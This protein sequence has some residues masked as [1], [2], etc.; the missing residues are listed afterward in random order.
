MENRMRMLRL[1]VAVVIILAM[2]LSLIAVPSFAA[3]PHKE[4]V[5]YLGNG[6]V[7]VEFDDDVDYENRRTKVIVRDTSGKRYKV[8][9][10]KKDDDE[11]RFRIKKFKK[12]KTYRFTI[13]GVRD[14]DT[15]SF[16]NVRGKVRIKKAVTKKVTNISRTKA[17][18]IA[19]ADA[20]KR[21]G[22]TSFY[23]LDIDKDRDDGVLIWEVDF[24]SRGYEYKYDIKV[25]GGK[26]LKRDIDRD[27]DY[28][29]DRDDRDDWDDRDDR[30]DDWD[31]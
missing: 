13:K 1:P 4:R 6:K 23:D 27:D 25:K 5:K 31:D 2:A 7:E 20:K 9:V 10:Y 15:R 19:Y 12:G 17:K 21:T 14:E 24:K 26:I 3:A 16:G 30:D 11:L 29:D 8:S 22:A 28:W 18:N